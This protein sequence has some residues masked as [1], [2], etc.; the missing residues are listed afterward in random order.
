MGMDYSPY[1]DIYR[2]KLDR[3]MVGGDMIS[4]IMGS[5]RGGMMGGMGGDI[6]G[7][8]GGM[9]GDRGG[10]IGGARGDYIDRR[11]F[12]R[13]SVGNMDLD[14]R[15]GDVD[16]FRQRSHGDSNG[17]YNQINHQQNGNR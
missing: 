10:M 16:D 17:H 13:R 14:D 6:G 2:S 4:S 12:D 5:D 9:G 11:S 3:G 8:I 1:S 7:M 15:L